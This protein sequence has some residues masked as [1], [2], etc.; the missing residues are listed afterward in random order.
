[1]S[2]ADRQRMLYELAEAVLSGQRTVVSA[3]LGQ[4]RAAPL[5]DQ[6][7]I[8]ELQAHSAAVYL[9]FHVLRSDDEPA[10]VA[11]LRKYAK[12]PAR[13]EQALQHI[14]DFPAG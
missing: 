3:Q 10:V 12:D 9:D 7:R 5:P 8:E 2:A 14:R 11:F 4:E 13:L 1:M 6:S